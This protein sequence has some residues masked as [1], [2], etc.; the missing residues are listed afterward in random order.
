MTI[1]CA[2]NDGLPGIRACTELGAHRVICPDNPGWA[3]STRPGT[4]RGCLPLAAEVGFLCRHCWDLVETAYAGWQRWS[5]LIVA[6]GG[7]AVAATGGGG[8][9]ALG[10]SNLSLAMLELDACNR[11]LA[12][13]EDLTLL[14]WVNTPAGA[15]HAIQFAHAALNAYRTLEVEE[16][17]KVTPPPARCPE[18]GLLT[19]TRNRERVVGAFTVVECQHCG[20]RLDK[21]RTGPDSWTGSRACEHDNGAEHLACTDVDC[22]CWCHHYGTKSRRAGIELLWDADLAAAAPGSAPRDAWTITDAHTITRRTA[23]TGRKTA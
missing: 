10:Y 17:A 15:A 22:G 9:S 12:T 14:M 1:V 11:H 18:C 16:H 20:H 23:D 3:E 19:A 5:T 2:T 6:A 4:C 13:R 8:S 21:I 7:R